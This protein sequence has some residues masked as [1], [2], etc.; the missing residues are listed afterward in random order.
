MKDSSHGSSRPEPAGGGANL[1]HVTPPPGVR[2]E[3]SKA[4]PQTQFALRAMSLAERFAQMCGKH[5]VEGDHTQWHAELSKP[6]GPSTG[7]GKQAVQHIKLVPGEG[8][9]FVIG[10]ANQVDGRVELRSFGCLAQIH[11]RRFRGEPIPFDQGTYEALL[12]R[13]RQFFS[14]MQMQVTLVDTLPTPELAVPS[15]RVSRRTEVYARAVTAV[16]GLALVV[17]LFLMLRR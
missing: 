11:R 2:P 1:R 13:M 15:G 16:A 12:E 4:R 9:T 5:Q 14:A 3:P 7:G 8:V 10:Q 6:D 17:V